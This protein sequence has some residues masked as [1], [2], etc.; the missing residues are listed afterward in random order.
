MNARTINRSTPLHFAAENGN[1]KH[2]CCTGYQF[3]F[4]TCFSS[5]NVKVVEI[6][7]RNEANPNL[8]N[9]AGQ[10]SLDLAVLKGIHF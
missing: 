5:G 8:K 3:N 2:L 9:N 7:M 10:T 1:W 4:A 6:L